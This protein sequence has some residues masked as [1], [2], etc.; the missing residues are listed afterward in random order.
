MTITSSLLSEKSWKKSLLSLP[1]TL[2]P[3]TF[4]DLL[5]FFD[6]IDK[7]YAFLLKCHLQP[8]LRQLRR[9][10][11]DL[12]LNTALGQRQQWKHFP[13]DLLRG[14]VQLCKEEFLLLSGAS[15][16]SSS[17]SSSSKSEERQEE[18]GEVLAFKT[19]S[20]GGAGHS[21][22]RKDCLLEALW[23]IT[24][25][26]F[27]HHYP[28]PPSPPSPPPAAA[29]A[30][31]SSVLLKE[32]KKNSQWPA[33]YDVNTCTL[34]MLPMPVLPQRLPPPPPPPP[35]P[36]APA[37][38]PSPPTHPPL[39]G[40]F[41]ELLE[42]LTRQSFYVNQMAH[43][44]YQPSRPAR[45]APL[46][47]PLPSFLT[48]RIQDL[49]QI[50]PQRFYLHQAKAI[51][52][53][54]RGEH[55][56]LATATASGKSLVFHLPVFESLCQDAQRVAIYLFPTKALAQDQLRSLQELIGSQGVLR[57]KIYPV[58]CDGDSSPAERRAIQGGV[59]N[60]ILT[61]PDMLHYTL[62]PAVRLLLL[63][64]HHHLLLLSYL[65]HDIAVVVLIA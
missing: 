12:V 22:K 41:A 14:I 52:A 2:L 40:A 39:Q 55:V 47:P 9:F 59:G 50:D 64:H 36:P 61:N 10:Y 57:E 34:S 62:L 5:L 45:Y 31:L 30:T 21:K 16:S 44:A 37:T 28:A 48:Q 26:H 53:V 15:S 58:V 6:V 25:T 27:L 38:T 20:G 35:P 32:I 19:L 54:R 23:G 17:S 60:I 4:Q 1:I 33:G 8:S 13:V 49:Y 29:P 51:Q 42:D 43:I 18:E 46:D 7:V 24:W 3:S 56:I 63:L 11:E 65:I